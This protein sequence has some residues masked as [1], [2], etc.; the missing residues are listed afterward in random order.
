MQEI[1]ERLNL[2]LK[3]EFEQVEIN[4]LICFLLPSGVLMNLFAIKEWKAVGV[5]YA[6]NSE[7]AK[8]SLFEDGDLFYFEDM[9]EE[10]LYSA[11]LTEIKENC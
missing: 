11:L 8:K 5:Q 7:E 6:N 2:R 10:E 3:M 9:T 1:L 4:G